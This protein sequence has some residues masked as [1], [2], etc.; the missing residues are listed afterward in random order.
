MHTTRSN[1]F[2]ILSK[3]GS[4]LNKQTNDVLMIAT[5][6]HFK[7]SFAF[8]RIEKRIFDAQIINAYKNTMNEESGKI[9]KL[10]KNKQQTVRKHNTR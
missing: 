9:I 5:T 3:S 7:S 4:G 2:S 1:T 6:S 8:L 10:L